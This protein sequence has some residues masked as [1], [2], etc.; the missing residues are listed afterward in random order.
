[1]IAERA[2]DAHFYVVCDRRRIIGCGGITGYWGS[3]AE[4]CL[5]SVFV[6]PEYKGRGIGKR[7]A[8]TP[9]SDE[10]FTRARRTEVGSPITD[11]CFRRKLG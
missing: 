9:E 2:A 7:I 11:V 3:A 6:L 5:L 10:F 8:E 4:S 1:M